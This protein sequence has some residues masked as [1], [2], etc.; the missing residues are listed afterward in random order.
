MLSK[1]SRR[2][3]LGSACAWGAAPGLGLLPAAVAARAKPPE[4]LVIW[5]TV[6]GAKGMRRVGEAFTAATGVPVVVETPDEGPAKFQQ[7]ASAGKGPDIYLYS[8]DRIGEWVAG[9]LLHAVTPPPRLLRDIDPMAWDGFQWRQRLW[10]Y[11][12][13]LEAL[14]LV[15]NKALLPT[16]PQN[17]EQV[18]ALDARLRPSGRS[19]ILW[20]YSNCYF[21]WP[22]LAAH[23]G[24][25][26]KR[27]ADGSYDAQDC[28]VDGPGVR[29]GAELLARMIRE[30]LMPVGSGYAEMEA[31]MA[32][33][34]V[35]MMING[36]WSW[37]NLQRAGVDF[38]I[39]RIP[40]VA[41]RPAAPYVG[42]K[43]VMINRATR[44]RELAVEF[45][46]HYLLS[47][48]GLR[49]IDQAEPIGAPASRSFYAE[50][51]AQPGKGERVVGIMASAR[52]GV[53]TPCIPEMGRFW[54]AMKSALLNL[55]EGRQTPA[56]A[57]AGAA[58]R[59]RE[60]A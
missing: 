13:A 30:G 2:Q 42:V 48:A 27:R 20:D 41:G 21:S 18:F 15:Y 54:S 26:F 58:R 36:P 16:P 3:L 56:E 59:I 23:G 47:P 33:G 44:Q 34:R 40:A 28:G 7:A 32:Q 22:L 19:A 24:Y 10:G 57:M 29:V 5:F 6:E 4:P 37:V 35:A 51:A 60:A 14:T 25:A 11:P 55:S 39:A 52:D 53:P 9:G 43:G 17:F 45:I 38:G 46:E 49:L 12:L 31:A 1:V 8:H 50:L